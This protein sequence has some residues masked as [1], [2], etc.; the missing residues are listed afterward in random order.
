MVSL[1]ARLEDGAAQEVG[2]V[3]REGLVG[4]S[5]VLGDDGTPVEHMVQGAGAALRVRAAELRAALER[6]ATLRAALLR[7]VQ[8]FHLQVTQTAVCNGRHALEQRLARW[9]LMAHDRFESDRF[10]M[11]QEFM[12]VMLGVWRPGVTIAAGILQKAGVIG[13]ER[14]VVV[15]LDRGRLEG[16]SCECYG[17]V[18]RQFARLLGDAAAG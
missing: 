12:A 17:T 5:V 11:T 7:Y 4:V 2:L 10:P 15:V 3:G 6:S 14:G 13:Y 9:L 1:L 16:A 18:R 8:A